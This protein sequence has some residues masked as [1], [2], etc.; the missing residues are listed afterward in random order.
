[1]HK[2]EKG[3]A[4]HAFAETVL[5]VTEKGNSVE[6]VELQGKLK[7]VYFEQYSQPT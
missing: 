5:A 1:M 4:S 6:Y 7:C 2:V 3:T